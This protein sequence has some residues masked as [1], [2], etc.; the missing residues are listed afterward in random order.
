MNTA[1]VLVDVAVKDLSGAALDWAVGVIEGATPIEGG[2]LEWTVGT[3][4][5]SVTPGMKNNPY[6][7]EHRGFG[8]CPSIDWSHGGPLLTKYRI[9]FGLYPG[10]YFAVI[11]TNDDAG[12]GHGPDHLTSACRAIVAA[13]HGD[14]VKVPA[15]LVMP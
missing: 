15:C 2:R 5:A 3:Q 4:K 8:Y 12:E 10:A 13:K 11:G 6:N 9:G 1:P 7:L 14:I